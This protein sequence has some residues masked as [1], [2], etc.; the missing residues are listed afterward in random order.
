MPYDPPEDVFEEF[1]KNIAP[2]RQ[3]IEIHRGASQQVAGRWSVPLDLLFID[4][5]HSYEGCRTDIEA[6]FPHVRSG[7][8]VAFHDSST[9]GV[10]R[11]IR[12]C[13][14]LARRTPGIRVWST[15][16]AL[17]R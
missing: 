3:R 7:G 5:D 14:P 10:A 6:W 15:F 17:K 1:A 11:A 9:E 4:G 2:H 8:V 13:L 16:V 12:E